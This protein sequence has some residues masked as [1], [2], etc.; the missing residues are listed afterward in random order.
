MRRTQPL[1]EL[2]LDS[3]RCDAT[4]CRVLRRLQVRPRTHTAGGVDG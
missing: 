2:L 3:L 4:V 1:L